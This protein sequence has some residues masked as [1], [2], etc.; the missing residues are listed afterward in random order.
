MDFIPDNRGIEGGSLLFP[1]RYQFIQCP[2]LQHRTREDMGADFGSFF[3]QANAEFQAL[4]H[5]QLAQANRGRETC[6]PAANNQ[7]IVFNNFSGHDN[8][9]IINYGG[10]FPCI[11]P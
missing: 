11:V 3:Q 10:N 9:R 1:V 6:G 2:R 8:M 5:G 7:H 4:F